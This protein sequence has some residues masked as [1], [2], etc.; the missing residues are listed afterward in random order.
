MILA[1]HVAHQ[2]EVTL[3]VTLLNYSLRSYTD[4]GD[5]C[6][7]PRSTCEG[8]FHVGQNDR[9]LPEVLQAAFISRW[10]KEFLEQF[11]LAMRV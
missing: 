10:C 8:F 5:L 7:D 9:K 1:I 2:E 3:K 6:T 4:C 11:G